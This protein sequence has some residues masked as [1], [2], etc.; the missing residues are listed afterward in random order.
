MDAALIRLGEDVTANVRTIGEIPKML[1]GKGV[2]DI[3]DVRGEIYME[4]EAFRE[5][6][7]TRL[8]NG[9]PL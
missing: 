4:T 8:R 6:N 3:I 5:L 1:S 7:R 9:G 2:P